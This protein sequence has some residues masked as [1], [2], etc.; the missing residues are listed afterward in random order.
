MRSGDDADQ[1]DH[2]QDQRQHGGDVIHQQLGLVM[3]APALVFAE[4]RHEGLRERALGEQ[5]AQQIGQLERDEEG[6]RRHARAEDP[7]DQHI[8]DEGQDARNQ[9]QA[10]DGRKD[11]EQIHFER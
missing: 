7:R 8:A 9:R 3:A 5:A 1:R 11:F 4:D 10:A 2:E 6:V